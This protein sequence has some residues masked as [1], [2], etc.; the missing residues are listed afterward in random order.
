MNEIAQEPTASEA[1]LLVLD[2]Q[3]NSPVQNSCKKQSQASSHPNLIKS[4]Q[5]DSR[6]CFTAPSSSRILSLFGNHDSAYSSSLSS[7]SGSPNSTGKSS[8]DDISLVGSQDSL[9]DGGGGDVVGGKWSSSLGEVLDD[10]KLKF[11]FQE[12]AVQNTREY[13]ESLLNSRACRN[14]RDQAL[15]SLHEDYISGKNSNY[16]LWLFSSGSKYLKSLLRIEDEEH[17]ND[18]EP[19]DDAWARY[20]GFLSHEVFLFLNFH[21]IL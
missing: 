8:N 4:F 3:E 11:G 2:T 12:D 17:C 19:R 6:Y 10:L 20:C 15:V 14:S 13:I 7:S 9:L 16:R 5:S 1:M 21:R 18:T